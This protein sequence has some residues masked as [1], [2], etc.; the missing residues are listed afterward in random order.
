MPR[1]DNQKFYSSAILL[2]GKSA[3][4]LNW[5]SQ[6]TQELRFDILLSLLPKNIN[7]LADAGCGFGDL[8]TYMKKKKTLPQTYIGIDSLV[9]MHS[10]ASNNSKQK[11][12]LADITKDE[13]PNADYYICSGAM[14]ILHYFETLLFIKNCF[15]ASRYGF[16]FNILYGEKQSKSYNYITRE[17]IEKIA[18]SLDVHRVEIRDAYMNNDITVGLFHI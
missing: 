18:I 1:I 9:Q 8:Y 17:K 3:R 5:R 12:V 14:N 4:G 15:R 10:I 11:I 7:T 16:V 6:K 13:I 2:H